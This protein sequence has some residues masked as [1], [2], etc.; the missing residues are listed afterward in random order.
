LTNQHGGGRGGVGRTSYN[1]FSPPTLYVGY[2]SVHKKKK[3]S[4]TKNLGHGFLALM[5][6]K[7]MVL[8]KKDWDSH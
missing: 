3:K 7:I 8:E 5:K 2:K 1:G 4:K 6:H